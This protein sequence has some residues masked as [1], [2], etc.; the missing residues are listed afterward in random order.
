MIYFDHAATSPCKEEILQGYI[1]ALREYGFNSES[2][3][4]DGVKIKRQ[5]DLVRSKCAELLG[6]NSDELFYTSGSTFSNNLGIIGYLNTFSNK[7]VRVITSKMEHSSVSHIFNNLSDNIEVCYCDN[8]EFGNLNLE[9]LE[10]LLTANT[11]LVTVNVVNN[12]LGN[13]ADLASIY[14]LVKHKSSALVFADYTQAIMKTS[15]VLE[16]CDMASLSAHKLGGLKGCGLFYKRRGVVIRPIIYGGGQELGLVPGTMN[17]PAQ[18][19]WYKTLRLKSEKFDVNYEY[20]S[21]LMNYLKSKLSN[22]YVINSS[23][24]HSP[25]IVSLSYLGF[26]SEVIMNHLFASQ[27]YVS[28]QSTCHLSSD[29]LS[30]VINALGISSDRVE[31][32]IR[33][34]FD[35]SNTFEEIDCFIETMERLREYAR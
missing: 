25:Y 7:L 23:T 14:K 5:L 17:A 30:E 27:I 8:D 13:V 33:L 12:E 35:E 2:L 24:N 18:L 15:N 3:Y 34:S 32:V 4:R 31:S 21:D 20:V 19:M 29:K 1:I 6:V 28:S 9:H 10:S 16:F 26:G 11:V 22:H